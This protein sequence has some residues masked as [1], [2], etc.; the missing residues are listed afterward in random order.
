MNSLEPDIIFIGGRLSAEYE[1]IANIAPT[2]LLTIDNATGYINGF[3]ANV[4]TIASIFGMEQATDELLAGFDARIAALNEA[5]AGNTAIVGLVTSSSFNTLGN[6]TRCSL[7]C[8][9]AGFENL[10]NDV[11]STHGDSASFE[12]LLEKIR[13]TSLCWT[14]TA[15]LEPRALKPRRR[16]WKMRL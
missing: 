1:N 14:A 2:V 11:D 5:A 9:E 8:N 6:G 15:P 3:K 4:G 13:I 10:A 16:L 7:I 12:L